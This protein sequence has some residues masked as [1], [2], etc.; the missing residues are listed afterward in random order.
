MEPESKEGKERTKAYN[1]T[2]LENEKYNI[3]IKTKT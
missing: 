1:K 2:T 3:T